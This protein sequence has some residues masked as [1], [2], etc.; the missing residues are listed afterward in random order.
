MGMLVVRSHAGANGSVRLAAEL[1]DRRNANTFTTAIELLT[2][3]KGTI[4]SH[5][6]VPVEVEKRAAGGGNI[7]W[8]D[9]IMLAAAEAVAI[10]GGPNLTVPLGRP[11]SDGPDLSSDFPKPTDNV[12][13]Q[14]ALFRASGFNTQELVALKGAHTL[15]YSRVAEPVGPLSST[16]NVFDNWSFGELLA[17]ESKLFTDQTLL[18]DPATLA[19]VEQYAADRALFFGDWASVF[20]K[21]SIQGVPAPLV[22][23]PPSG[24]GAAQSPQAAAVSLASCPAG[25]NCSSAPSSAGAPFASSAS[26]P[27]PSEASAASC[28]GIL[29]SSVVSSLFVAAAVKMFTSCL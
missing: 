10:T 24:G 12:T 1:A 4:D 18:D 23:P 29:V 26:D 20:T 19:W 9:L 8:A 22:P 6:E 28:P 11:D 27:P 17:S 14:V 25:S 3:A 21:L 2:M 16:P 13:V 15:G 5:Y 7:T